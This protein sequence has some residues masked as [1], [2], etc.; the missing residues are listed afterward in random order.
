MEGVSHSSSPGRIPQNTLE[1][2]ARNFFREASSY[3]FRQIDYLRFV[4]VLLG[5]SIEAEAQ[6]NRLEAGGFWECGTEAD[7]TDQD[8]QGRTLPISS[9]RITIR[10]FEPKKDLRML[11]VWLADEW[12]RHF[13]L[14]RSTARVMNCER[15]LTSPDH[16][17]GIITLRDGLPVGAIA[18]LNHDREQHKAELR[19]LIGVASMRG[20]GLGKEASRLWIR[21]G[22]I[23]LR[24]KKI[25]LDTLE[26]NLHNIRIN[27]DLGFKVEGILRNEILL[28]GQ[29]R[30]VLRM[31]LWIG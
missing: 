18:Y 16:H 13:L 27:E 1:I 12:G 6:A 8:S 24:L 21:Y 17:V 3:G 20:F 30:D 2:L 29:Y 15:L 4:N 26:T 10:A 22:A 19:K 31:G 9:E 14:S 5:V 7:A 23:G 25:Y 28:D 11:E